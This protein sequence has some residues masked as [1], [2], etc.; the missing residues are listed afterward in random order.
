MLDDPFLPWVVSN[1]SRF[2]DK[3]SKGHMTI[4]RMTIAP[5]TWVQAG[6]TREASLSAALDPLVGAL[7]RSGT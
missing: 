6:G 4:E 2:A 7:V 3:S 1:R 5:R